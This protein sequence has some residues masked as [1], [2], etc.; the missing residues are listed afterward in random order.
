GIDALQPAAFERTAVLEEVPPRNAVLRGQHCGLGPAEVIEVGDDGG[1]LMRLHAEDD[2]LLC[3][4]LGNLVG[5][6]NARH[7]L[8]AVLLDQL[9]A[10]GLDGC[11]MRTACDHADLFARLLQLGCEQTADGARADNANPHSWAFSP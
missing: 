11:E 9:Q 7:D 2:E 6:S 1:N 8:T 3:A 5:G 4:G 10:V